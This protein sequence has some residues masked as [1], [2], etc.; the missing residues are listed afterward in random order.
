MYEQE[1]G[2]IEAV[3]EKHGHAPMIPEFSAPVARLIVRRCRT[4][5]ISPPL[6]IRRFQDRAEGAKGV[7]GAQDKIGRDFYG[8][9]YSNLTPDKRAEVDSLHSSLVADN[10]ATGHPYLKPGFNFAQARHL[11]LETYRE[12]VSTHYPQEIQTALAD[13]RTGLEK[14]LDEAAK[15]H[16]FYPEYSGANQ[17]LRIATAGPHRAGQSIPIVTARR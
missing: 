17:A 5:Q 4:L 10:P 8:T 9:E 2:Q 14:D 1:R 12:E 15:V 13:F 11:L 3:A 16:G 6:V 7:T